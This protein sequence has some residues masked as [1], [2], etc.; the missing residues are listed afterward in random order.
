MTSQGY[1]VVNVDGKGYPVHRVS[2]S[3]VNGLI[4]LGFLVHHHC[5]NKRCINPG[6]LE[7]VLAA[8]NCAYKRKEYAGTSQVVVR[9]DDT[10]HTE[11]RAAAKRRN[12]KVADLVRPMLHYLAVLDHV[13]PIWGDLAPTMRFPRVERVPVGS[14][15]T[16]KP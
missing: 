7:A 6:H 14:N 11:L 5:A 13:D 1:A 2:C 10:I 4:P 16:K 12:V 9:V 8:Q 15:G 3:E